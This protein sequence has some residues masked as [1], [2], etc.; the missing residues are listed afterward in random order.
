MLVHSHAP[1]RG[2]FQAGVSV[3]GRHVFDIFCRNTGNFFYFF[4]C[5]IFKK[6][7][8]IFKT[9]PFGFILKGEM[10]FGSIADIGLSF[11]ERDMLI[12]KVPVNPVVFDDFVTDGVGNSEISLGSEED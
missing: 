12:D 10:I 7:F 11:M 5:V 8:E 9:D 2:D 1:E 6:E 3:Q 4:G